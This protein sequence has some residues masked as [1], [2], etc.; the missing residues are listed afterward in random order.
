MREFKPLNPVTLHD[1]Y[2]VEMEGAEPIVK[3]DESEKQIVISYTFP[4]FQLSDDS[5]KVEGKTIPFK[6]VN[7]DSTGFYAE[8]G[9]PLLPSFGRYVQIPHNC[10]Y[11]FKVKTGKAVEFDDVLVLPAQEM[12]TD[13]PEE[14]HVFEYDK[15]MYKKDGLYPEN[16]VEIKGPHIID[17]YNSLLVH[18]RPLQYNPAKKRLTGYGDIT[19]TIKVTPKKEEAGDYP[20]ADPGM[21][22]EAFGNLFLNPSRAINERLR[23]PAGKLT[24][25]GFWLYGPEFMIIFYDKFKQAAE[26]LEKWK[27]TR[28]MRAEIVPI[29]DIGNDHNKIKNYIRGKRKG[30]SRLRY[31]LLLGDVEMIESENIQGGPYGSNITD[32]YYSTSKDAADEYDYVL[33]WLSIGRIPVQTAA[34]A[35]KVV[36]QIISYEKSPPTDTDYYER[37]VFAAYFQDDDNVGEP[38]YGTADRAYMKT[39][40]DIRQHMTPL[41]YDIERIYV[42]NIPNPQFYIDG[43]PVPADVKAVITDEATATNTLVNATSEGQLIAAHRD[44]GGPDGWL[45]PPFKLNNLNNVSGKIP[46]VFF[47]VNCMTGVFDLNAATECFAER[48]L[49]MEGAAPSLVAATRSSHT[50]LNNDLMKALFDAMWG[51]VLPTFPSA[52]ASYPVRHNRL[53][54]ILNYGKAYLPVEMSGSAR[55]I[56]DH[57]EIYHVVGDPTL[58]LW[59]E[60]PQRMKVLALLQRDYLDIILSACP[61]D[62]IITVWWKDHLIKKIEPSSRHV[63]VALREFIPFPR[64]VTESYWPIRLAISVCFWAPGYRF[65]EVKPRVLARQPYMPF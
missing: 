20:F 18:V 56:K 62:S 57:Y 27:K 60:E 24:V 49:R 29:S 64:L 51:G 53:G 13:S 59:K 41:G 65:C 5:R 32:Y 2:D 25:P 30:L 26:K 22:R 63:R 38:G 52:T 33:P 16:I 4:G 43:T 39:M 31:V 45:H 40:E 7:I 55:Y 6:Q 46:T 3:L 12:I 47:S 58:E 19:V 44:H 1:G 34:E 10:D 54:D 21:E 17:D 42:A 9:K 36:D 15:A 50:W 35:L 28:G 61:K 48:I 37:M 14:K 23:I 11:E 8:S